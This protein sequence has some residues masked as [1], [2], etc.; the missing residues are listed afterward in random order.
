MDKLQLDWQYCEC[1]CKSHILHSKTPFPFSVYNDLKG[2]YW[3][4]KWCASQYTKRYD[5]FKAAED[6]VIE[7]M[8]NASKPG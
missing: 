3:L 2:G 4:T 8:E 7:E 5:S 6:A 1:G